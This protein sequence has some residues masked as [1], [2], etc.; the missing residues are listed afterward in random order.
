LRI[1]GTKSHAKAATLLTIERVPSCCHPPNWLGAE[2]FLTGNPRERR[3]AILSAAKKTSGGAT[4]LVTAPCDDVVSQE[5]RHGSQNATN[6][7]FCDFGAA[8]SSIG[9]G[10]EITVFRFLH[11]TRLLYY[12]FFLLLAQVRK[13]N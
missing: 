9:E 11:A 8:R 10:R 3:H 2:A 6:F 5:T 13:N 1:S 7:S 12:G 4:S